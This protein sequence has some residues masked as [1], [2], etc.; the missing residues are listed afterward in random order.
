MLQTLARG[1]GPDLVVVLDKSDEVVCG[2]PIHR[3]AMPSPAVVRIF[4]V[5]Y[6]DVLQRLDQLFE[7]SKIVVIP[8]A[9]LFHMQQREQRMMEVI[10]PLRVDPEQIGRASC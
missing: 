4:S 2:E 1:P 7:R 8:G 9:P 10:A 6:E 5:V 3:P